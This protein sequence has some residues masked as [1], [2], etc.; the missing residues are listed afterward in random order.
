VDASLVIV[1]AAVVFTDAGDGDKGGGGGTAENK[2]LAAGRAHTA[3]VVQLHEF[4]QF[5]I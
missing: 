4:L 1:R 3:C 2:Q 5:Q